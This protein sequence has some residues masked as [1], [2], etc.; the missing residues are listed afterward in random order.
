MP[1]CAWLC[2]SITNIIFKASNVLS[3]ASFKEILSSQ[4]NN[5]RSAKTYRG[6]RFFVT[7]RRVHIPEQRVWASILYMSADMGIRSREL[8]IIRESTLLVSQT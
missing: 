7:P 5:P 4:K 6:S 1:V 3:H 8:S 2:L